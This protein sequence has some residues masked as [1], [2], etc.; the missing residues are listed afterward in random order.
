MHVLLVIAIIAIT[1]SIVF[2]AISLLIFWFFDKPQQIL[3]L[4]FKFKKDNTDCDQT[5]L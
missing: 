1:S 2:G 4:M 3:D 5:N